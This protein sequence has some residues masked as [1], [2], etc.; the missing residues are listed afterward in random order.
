[1]TKVPKNPIWNDPELEICFFEG[2][3]KCMPFYPNKEFSILNIQSEIE[4]KLKL[5]VS[6]PGKIKI[7]QTNF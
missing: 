4:S 6:F 3:I 7:F 5:K 1:M 2:L